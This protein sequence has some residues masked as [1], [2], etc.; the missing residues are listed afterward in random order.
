M[1]AVAP[2]Y[3]STTAVLPRTRQQTYL[4]Q[5][6]HQWTNSWRERAT[7]R[8]SSAKRRCEIGPPSI[9]SMPPCPTACL[10]FRMVMSK[11]KKNNRG[12]RARPC[13]TPPVI[14]NWSLRPTSPTIAPCCPQYTC[15]TQIKC[16]GTLAQ[17]RLA[18][19]LANVP[20]QTPWTSP[21]WCS[22]P[23]NG[24]LLLCPRKYSLIK[25]ALQVVV[26]HGNHVVF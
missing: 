22:K 4:L 6:Y 25:G 5:L 24:L 13:R 8:I 11:T 26:L 7:T 20:G 17:T 19:M 18:T 10:H 23:E 21:R 15:K 1:G 12:L 9:K 2:H 16:W 14:G 3:I